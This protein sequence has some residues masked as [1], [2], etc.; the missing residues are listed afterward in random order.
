M[1]FIELIKEARSTRRFK[2]KEISMETLKKLVEYARY[3]PSGANRQ[4][5]KYMFITDRELRNKVNQQI[6]WAGALNDW[7]GPAEGEQPMAYICILLD[8]TI[9]TN[10]GVD[11]GIAAQSIVLG[12]K[13]LGLGSCIIGA[14]NKPVLQKLLNFPDSLQCLLIIA[15]GEAGERVVVDDLSAGQSMAYY[16]DE[17]NVHHVPKR[18]L[19]DLIWTK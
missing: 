9:G 17:K 5:L 11:H 13:S 18:K 12:A 14:F 3:S 6:K 8:K 1:E 4:L 16:R 15:L 7:K 10:P 19:E 2:Q